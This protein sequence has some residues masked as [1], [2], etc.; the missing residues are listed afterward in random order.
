MQNNGTV[1]NASVITSTNLN[2]NAG[3]EALLQ[4][5]LSHI[6]DNIQVTMSHYSEIRS[7]HMIHEQNI[8]LL[9]DISQ[10]ALKEARNIA[11][12]QED[13]CIA[14]RKI[15][16]LAL[17]NHLR[18]QMNYNASIRN[19]RKILADLHEKYTK[20]IKSYNTQSAAAHSESEAMRIYLYNTKISPIDK[21]DENSSTH[22]F[23]VKSNINICV[24]TG[25]SSNNPTVIFGASVSTST[26]SSF[27]EIKRKFLD[28]GSTSEEVGPYKKRKI[29]TVVP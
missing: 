12:V 24:D 10:E 11:Q 29:G 28:T 6:R 14:S 13:A 17:Q 19:R 3:N 21:E 27:I 1:R 22:V 18:S 2:I 4:Y 23:G 8:R 20:D 9:Y 25:I 7:H 26:S 5:K 16:E 15:L